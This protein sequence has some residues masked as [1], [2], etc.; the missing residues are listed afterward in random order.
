MAGI[1]NILYYIPFLSTCFC[2]GQNL[3]DIK[4]ADSVFGKPLTTVLAEVKKT[5]KI[6]FYYLPEWIN[7]LELSNPRNKNATLQ[8]A[9]DLTFEGLGLTYID[10]QKNSIVI[11]NYPEAGLQR[12]EIIK[13]LKQEKKPLLK[14]TTTRE[15]EIKGSIKLSG[16][17][18]DTENNRPIKNSILSISGYPGPIAQDSGYFNLHLPSGEYILNLT[19][20]DYEAKFIDLMIYKDTVIDFHLSESATLLDEIVFEN[21]VIRESASSHVGEIKLSPAEIKFFPPFLGEVD[22]VKQIQNLPGVTTAGEAATGF[23][24]RGGSIDQNLVLFDGMPIFNTS[25]AFGFLTAFNPSSVGSIT[26]YKGGIPAQYGGRTSSILDIKSKDG[27]FT[28]WKGK[29]GIGLVTSNFEM[30][31]PLKK[32]KASLAISARSTYSNWLVRSIRTDYTDLSNS[33]VFFY[34]G[35][36]KLSLRPSN[37]DNVSISLYSSQDAFRISGDTTYSWNNL[38]LSTSWN[39]II[40]ERVTMEIQSGISHYG[41]NIINDEP[42]TASELEYQV[43]ANS[44]KAIFEFNATP[45]K[46]QVGAELLVSIYKPGSLKPTNSTS[47]AARL[48]LPDQYNI[49][50]SVFASAEK[51][52]FN[53]LNIELGLRIPLNTSLGNGPVYKYNPDEPREL[54]N[55]T[56]TIHFKKFEPVK[57]YIGFEPRLSIKWAIKPTSSLKF[58]YNRMLQFLHLVTNTVAATPVDVWQ[59]TNYYFKPQV[60]NQISLGYFHDFRNDQ[61]GLSAETYYKNMDGVL[62][63]KDG[64]KLILN[65]NLET[66]LIQGKGYAYGFETALSK[67]Y[68]ILTGGFNYTFSRSFR[69]FNGPFVNEKINKGKTYPANFDQ[70]HMANAYWKITFRKRFS[71]TG[72]FTYR[73]GRPITIPLAAFEFENATVAYFS[74]RNQYRISDYHRLDLAFIINGN[75]KRK[76]TGEGTWTFSVYNVYARRNPYTIFFKGTESGI[77]KPYQLSI[78]GT[79][80]PSISYSF[81]F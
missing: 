35:N 39:K 61:Y 43:Y 80:F 40:N 26:F 45:Y 59:P 22:V 64:T 73:T 55:I 68:G 17:I 63:F 5:N 42:R 54:R 47:N 41:Y 3:A 4:L 30:N 28:E 29:A 11:L 56:D 65:N 9:L 36:I 12:L 2:W 13:K 77:P 21:K 52:I 15:R 78:I 53:K 18:R 74:G 7:G 70:P 44:S 31:G 37:R 66:G 46:L 8:E 75:N 79:A 23:N 24:V 33:S 81:I 57:T 34:D 38:V 10:V 76:K 69:T 50:S 71:F 20:P 19:A 62:D 48:I 72:N 25:H 51:D 27:G 16:Q 67:N 49:E 32:N 6:D 58:G 60:V 1:K 14:V